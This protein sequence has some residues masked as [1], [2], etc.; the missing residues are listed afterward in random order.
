[1]YSRKH[2]KHFISMIETLVV[3][4][5]LTDK[6]DDQFYPNNLSP[7]QGGTSTSTTLSIERKRGDFGHDKLKHQLWANM[8]NASVTKFI[9]RIP[10]FDEQD[11]LKVNK[12]TGYD[13]AYTGSGDVAFYKLEMKFGDVTKIITKVQIGQHPRLNAAALVDY[14]LIIWHFSFP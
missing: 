8:V 10:Q 14:L 9:E 3:N 6:S 12:I 5:V 7:I 1:M 4:G 11:I 13:I 2:R